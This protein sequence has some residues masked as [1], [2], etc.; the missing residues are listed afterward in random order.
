MG[1]LILDGKTVA[2][3]VLQETGERVA[4]LRER[5]KETTLATVLV[6]EDQASAAYV[7]SKRRRA[8]ELGIRSV[9]QELSGDITQARVVDLLRSLNEDPAIDG[10]LLQLPLPRGAG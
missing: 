1:A 8:A 5:G 6:G 4:A 7:R 2:K 10:I 9:H 3:A